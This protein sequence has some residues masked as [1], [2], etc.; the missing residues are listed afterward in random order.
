MGPN[1]L[2]EPPIVLES[3]TDLQTVMSTGLVGEQSTSPHSTVVSLQ[4]VILQLNV[5]KT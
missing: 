2:T 3:F 4:T 1:H 5:A